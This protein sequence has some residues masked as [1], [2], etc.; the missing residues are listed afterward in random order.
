MSITI[1]VVSAQLTRDTEFFSNMVHIFLSR[2]PIASLDLE[3]RPSAPIP[4]VRQEKNQ[5]G[6]NLFASAMLTTI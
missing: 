2:I 6:T 3:P 4:R 5:F 1:K